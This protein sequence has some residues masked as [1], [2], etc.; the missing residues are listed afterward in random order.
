MWI[1]RIFPDKIFDLLV[2]HLTCLCSVP[3][4]W[5][6]VK[7]GRNTGVAE[8]IHPLL[9]DFRLNE[10]RLGPSAG[11]A[12]T[13][14][15]CRILSIMMTTPA[16][17]A[18]LGAL[19]AAPSRPPQPALDRYIL[20][21][22]GME[23]LTRDSRILVGRYIRQLAEHVGFK[24]LRSDVTLTVP[25]SATTGAIYTRTGEPVRESM[26]EEERAAWAERRIAELKSEAERSEIGKALFQK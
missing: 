2:I 7:L 4:I 17:S 23:A 3:L 13:P 25:A 20:P 6:T 21:A 18:L 12:E 14:T 26:T 19:E 5:V 9:H 15:G 8:D 24:W 10:G 1:S 22:I 16:F 11:F